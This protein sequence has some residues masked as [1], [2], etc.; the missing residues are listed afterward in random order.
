MSRGR[1]Q[2]RF[3]CG[4]GA[5]CAFALTPCVAPGVALG[6]RPD[7]PGSTALFQFAPTEVVET[8]DVARVRVHFTTDGDNA[9]P[10]DDRDASGV[11]DYV[12]EVAET[13]QDA[14]AFFEAEGFRSPLSDDALPYN[15]GDAR[16]DVYL[17]DFFGSADGS[18]QVDDSCFAAQCAGYMVQENDFAEQGYASTL[19]ATRIVGSHEL[20]HAIQAAYD[21]DQGAIFSEG[22]ATWATERFDP[23]SPDFERA[24]RGYLRDPERP[25]SVDTSGVVLDPF[26]YG[27]ALFF[28]FLEERFD[29]ELVR[30]LLEGTEDGAMGV[31]DPHWFDVLGS[32]LVGRGSTFEQEMV[33]FARWNLLLGSWAVPETGYRDAVTYSTLVFRDELL[34]L[35]DERPRH[36][37]A[38]ARYYRAPVQDRAQVR[39]GLTEPAGLVTLLGVVRDGTLQLEGPA[40]DG[41]TL[42]LDARGAQEVV[43][44]VVNPSVEGPSLRSSVCLGSPDEVADCLAAP[45]GDPGEPT[46]DPDTGSES[47]GPQDAGSSDGGG[48]AAMPDSGGRGCQLTQAKGRANPL[49]LLGGL[50]FG[51][52]CCARRVGR[53]RTRR[54]S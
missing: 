38:A 20:F 37:H 43:A 28:R 42:E 47:D 30:Q 27:S 29:S 4:L 23:S 32:A 12:E 46:E 18:F 52:F 25:I 31:E 49:G 40:P 7:T 26:S 53:T 48:V 10:P 45:V 35:R 5:A 15:G 24:I 22:T 36:F 44:V 11:P 17:V 8:F 39:L 1:D 14:L 9:V 16:F 21:R 34:P 2:R 33:E 6:Q 54:S 51:L 19:Q 3:R 50:A 41:A 13:Y